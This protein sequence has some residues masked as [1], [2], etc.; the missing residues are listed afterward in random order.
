MITTVAGY[1]GGASSPG[2]NLQHDIEIVEVGYSEPITADEARTYLRIED[3][4]IEDDM[5][6][7][8]ITAARQA[9]EQAA[10]ISLIEKTVT[11]WFSNPE[12]MY[13]IPVGPVQS[14]EHLY[15]E[16]DN[17]INS[18]EY[19]IIGNQYPKLKSPLQNFMKLEY[20]VGMTSVPSEIKQ[21]LLDQVYFL[22]EDRGNDGDKPLCE[23]VQKVVQKW[24]KYGFVA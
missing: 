9:F 8:M 14:I 7:T 20:T 17:E 10:Q 2:Y 4:A 23:K 15:D 6:D 13:P 1:Y 11:L 24:S 18:D 21:A 19:E 12:G 16:E 22:Y 3:L 5:I